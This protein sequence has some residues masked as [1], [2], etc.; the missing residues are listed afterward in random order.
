MRLTA[1]GWAQWWLWLWGIVAITL[2]ALVF[3]IPFRWWAVAAGVGF[4]TLEGIGVVRD[5]RYPPLT[6][7]IHK[8]VPRWAAFTAIYGFMGGAGAVWFGV[9]KPWRLAL[10]A[11]L[12][13]WLTT[14]FDVT[15]D[16]DK[17]RQERAK[18]QRLMAG[19]KRLVPF[20]S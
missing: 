5:D 11:A 10:F 18:N 16:D 1:H 19:A 2:L 9:R 7:V 13:G 15:F 20:K 17:L 8:Y 3:V 4:G 12:L 14:H 6:H